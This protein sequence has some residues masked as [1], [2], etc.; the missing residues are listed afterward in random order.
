[1][2]TT[3]RTGRTAAAAALIAA[4]G[5]AG[6]LHA[7]PADRFEGVEVTARQ[8]SGSVY[9]LT[10][11]GGNIGATVGPDGTLIIDD[12]FAPLAG[13]IQEALNGIGGDKPRLVLNTHFHGD[14]TGSNAH[15]GADGTIIAHENVR[16]RLLGGGNVDRAALPLV[17]YEQSVTVHF[18][19]E[20]LV[21]V[22]LPAGHTDG[23]SA[24]WFKNANVIHM[25]DH[26]FVDRFPFVDQAS[27]GTVSGFVANLKTVLDMVPDDIQVI[28]GHG[29]LSG[30][31]AISASIDMIEATRA[32]VNEAIAA[33]ASADEVVEQGLPEEWSSF[34]AGFINEERWIRILAAEAGTSG[35]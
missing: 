25:G 23:D 11:A 31:N 33:G 16:I 30:K 19:D 24:V 2:T 20:E 12:Q 7:G 34:G 18:N 26:L 6:W 32:I 8:V 17:T 35:S 21:V 5:I 29:P 13:K 1:M 14:H 3:T 15:F 22:H 27:G 10:G 9:M 28:P 4:A